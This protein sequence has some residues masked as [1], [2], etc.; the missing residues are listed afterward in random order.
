MHLCKVEVAVL[1]LVVQVEDLRDELAVRCEAKGHARVH[2]LDE[3]QLLA[4]LVF[5]RHD[6]AED[7]LQKLG[8][9]LA[10]PLEKLVKV[11]RATAVAVLCHQITSIKN[12]EGLVVCSIAIL[13]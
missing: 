8:L 1:V 5:L 7:E 12:R 11:Y 4:R 2:P 3:V 13:R 10:D 9:R 6:D